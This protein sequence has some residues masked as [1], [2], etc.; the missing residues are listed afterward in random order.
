MLDGLWFRDHDATSQSCI[1][2]IC[3][4]HL[5]VGK[6]LLYFGVALT[7]SPYGMMFWPHPFNY[8]PTGPRWSLMR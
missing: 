8:P 3:D 7:V 2:R 5:T 1:L 6:R 4:I